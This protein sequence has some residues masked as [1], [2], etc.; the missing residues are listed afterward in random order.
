MKRRR[1]D[2]TVKYWVSDP[3]LAAEDQ[4]ITRLR[5]GKQITGFEFPL[6]DVSGIPMIF[7][8][9]HGNVAWRAGLT[10]VGSEADE[11]GEPVELAH[12]LGKDS[13]DILEKTVNPDLQQGFNLL[14]ASSLL[15]VGFEKVKEC[16]R[17]PRNAFINALSLP[18][19][20]FSRNHPRTMG[21]T[22]RSY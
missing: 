13:Y 17:V 1:H 12:L 5:G 22:T 21:T 19:P 6:L 20:G 10:I 15:V 4:L 8:A 2:V 11:Q 16:I 3:L 14:Q 7:L 18:I 9:D